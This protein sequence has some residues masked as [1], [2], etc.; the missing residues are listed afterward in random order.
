MVIIKQKDGDGFLDDLRPPIPVG[1]VE[2]SE[3]HLAAVPGD[4]CGE[5]FLLL[6]VVPFLRHPDPVAGILSPAE[7]DAVY[8]S[9]LMN[10]WT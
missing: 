7:V 2:C 8:Q 9:E 4:F 1:W 10:R 5:K 3:T 6:L